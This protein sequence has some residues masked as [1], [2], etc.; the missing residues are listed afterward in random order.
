MNPDAWD[1]VI[2]VF[3]EAAI[4]SFC[5]LLAFAGIAHLLN[6]H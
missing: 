4:V 6:A 3:V 5:I 1:K 2:R